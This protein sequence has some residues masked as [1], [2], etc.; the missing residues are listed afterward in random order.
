MHMPADKL[1]VTP[2]GLPLPDVVHSVLEPAALQS[3]RAI[4][5]GDVHGCP[6]ELDD[7]LAKCRFE[8]HIDKLI[9]VGDIVARACSLPRLY[10][11]PGS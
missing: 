4:I 11:A 7:L 6:E 9:L 10:S 8:E 1:L 2:K 3:G 5:V